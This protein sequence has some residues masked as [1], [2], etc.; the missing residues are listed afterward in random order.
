MYNLSRIMTKAWE[1]FRKYN[2]AV[3]FGECLHRA[4]LSEKS[5]PENA[6]R[7]EEARQAAGIT[8]ECNTW[9]AW[10]ELGFE[11]I[12]ESRALFKAVLIY[13]S[14]GDGQTYTASFFGASQVQPIAA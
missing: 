6:R 8:E 5:K 14:K 4:W 1:L 11:V 10:R 2:K 13:A 7:I 12:H 9:K 3:S